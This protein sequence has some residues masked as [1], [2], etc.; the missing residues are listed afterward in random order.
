VEPILI[1]E[2]GEPVS[3]VLIGRGV[4]SDPGILLGDMRFQRI[5]VFSQESVAGLAAEVAASLGQTGANV[6][7]RSLPDREDAKTIGVAEACYRW[8][9]GLG[10]TRHDLIVGVGGGALTDVAGFVA[11]TYLRGLPAVFVPTTLLGAV[12]AAIGGKT[13]VN[14]DGKNLVGVF[15]HPERV[16]IDVEV[17]AALPADVLREGHA[18]AVKAGFIADPAILDLYERHGAAAPLD[19]IVAKAVAVKAHVV[20]EDFK[21][22][23][24]RAALNYGH[25][26]GHAVETLAGIPHGD[27]VAIGMVAA[28]AASARDVGFTGERRQR[29]I[30]AS[31]GLPVTAP[32][33]DP[34]EVR[35]V[36]D[37]D[38]K[39]DDSGLRM[40]LLEDFG[41]PV[42]RTTGA[43]TVAVA[44]EAIGLE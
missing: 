12:D 15:K 34:A 16:V 19:E 9:N 36:M 3:R 29:G 26:V 33:I 22:E 43:A 13:A 40:V 28:G 41:R 1:T 17:L 6:A 42:L 24:G 4:F 21:E 5:A 11:G 27:A 25:T 20:S 39:R 18:E 8:L 32:D 23:G 44:L 31:L 2:R 35:A 37:L 38:K 10:M 14:V 30:I 7:T